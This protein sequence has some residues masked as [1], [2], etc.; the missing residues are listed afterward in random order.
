MSVGVLVSMDIDTVKFVM[1]FCLGGGIADPH[2]PERRQ[3]N[4][5]KCIPPGYPKYSQNFPIQHHEA[6][7]QAS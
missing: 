6:H 1:R 2:R 3:R 7:C 5:V 4:E